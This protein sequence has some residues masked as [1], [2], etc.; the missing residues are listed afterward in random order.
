VRYGNVVGSRGSVIPFFMARKK[1]GM[2]PITDP[3]MTRFWITLQQGVDFVIDC[4]E[5]MYGG[6][7]YVPK[8]PSM[9]IM[10]LANAIAPECKHEVVGI[11]P[12]EKLHEVMV[13]DDDA[14]NT[15]ELDDR[16]VVLPQ[17]D[18]SW[19]PPAYGNAKRCAEGFRYASDTNDR[20]LTRDQLVDM[21]K[22]IS[23]EQ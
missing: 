15:V 17:F 21:T 7:L 13:T 9:N 19:I 16:Y 14:R 10:D 23:V 2:L 18:Y 1:T 6:E 4:L 11:R 5:R 12:G 3:R 20:W 8:I 22:H